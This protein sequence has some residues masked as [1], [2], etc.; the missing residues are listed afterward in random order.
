VISEVDSARIVDRAARN[1]Q[2]AWADLV[3]RYGGMLRAIA[4]GFR[5]NQ[6]DAEDAVQTTWLD[7]V[8]TIGNLRSHDR[9]AGWLS[10]TMRRNCMRILQRP[11]WEVLSDMIEETTADTAASV[12]DV[13]LAAEQARQLWDVVEILPDRQARLLH[14]L[15][16]ED[17]LSY[18]DVA[19]ALAMPVGAIGPVRQRALRTLA[20]MLAT[21]A[22]GATA[23]SEVLRPCA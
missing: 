11:R 9:I 6:S 8:R 10:T 12:E 2:Q 15:F 13:V 17:G 18:R 4:G 22:T 1:D 14:V 23:P 5:L 16:A 7:L 21:G 3:H 19:E 20:R